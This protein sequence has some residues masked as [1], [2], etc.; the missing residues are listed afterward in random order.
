MADIYEESEGSKDPAGFMFH[1]SKPK[2]RTSLIK[3]PKSDYLN[4]IME[5][6]VTLA[7]HRFFFLRACTVLTTSSKRCMDS[8]DVLET[9][10]RSEEESGGGDKEAIVVWQL[11]LGDWR[12]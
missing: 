1:F 6:L 10:E 5:K 8:L 3:L 2:V 11:K 9:L 4:M 12:R 7:T